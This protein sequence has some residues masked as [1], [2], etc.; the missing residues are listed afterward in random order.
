MERTFIIAERVD[1]GMTC[2]DV[3]CPDGG[4]GM[5]NKWSNAIQ[6]LARYTQ[7]A[8]SD[9]E[10]DAFS[11][12]F[13]GY[14]LYMSS[15][16]RAAPMTDIFDVS[17]IE[18][19]SLERLAADCAAFLATKANDENSVRAVITGLIASQRYTIQHA[20]FDF[21]LTR[22]DVETGFGTRGFG[23]IGGA[24]TEIAA[25]FGPCSLELEE[26]KLRYRQAKALLTS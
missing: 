17:D 26:G 2:I 11:N 15:E 22:N 24:L 20:A 16:D 18:D 12:A 1:G 21:W 6:F 13:A 4:K 10:L 7:C 3:V 19:T 5:F 9:V 8:A 23:P 14:G 25:R